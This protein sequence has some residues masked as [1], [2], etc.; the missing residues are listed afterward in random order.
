MVIWSQ[1]EKYALDECI[2]LCYDKNFW[3]KRFFSLEILYK[4][5]FASVQVFLQ[6]SYL[7]VETT[8]FYRKYHRLNIC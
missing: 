6:D 8:V 1:L 4:E 5:F 7:I 2:F 3:I